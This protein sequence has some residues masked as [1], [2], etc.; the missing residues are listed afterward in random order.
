M[1]SNGF[2][3]TVNRAKQK[4]GAIK[5]GFFITEKKN[6]LNTVKKKSQ[7]NTLKIGDNIQLP[8]LWIN[9]A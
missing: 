7:N 6:I 2:P 5:K 9:F 4:E 1:T 3:T 8:V